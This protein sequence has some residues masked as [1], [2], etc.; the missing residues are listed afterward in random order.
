M[1]VGWNHFCDWW[2][3]K[4]FFWKPTGIWILN[5]RHCNEQLVCSNDSL[6][7]KKDFPNMELSWWF[8]PLTMAYLV[9]QMKYRIRS[10]SSCGMFSKCNAFKQSLVSINATFLVWLVILT[11]LSNQKITQRIHRFKTGIF[12]FERIHNLAETVLE[13]QKKYFHG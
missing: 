12:T 13:S 9:F 5:M 4:E 7:E 1:F 8:G 10:S 11:S 2:N 6:E 3:T